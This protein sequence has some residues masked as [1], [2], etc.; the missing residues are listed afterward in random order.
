MHFQGLKLTANHNAFRPG[1]DEDDHLYQWHNKELVP[2]IKITV[3]Y[4]LIFQP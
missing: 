1:A 3:K 2:I 4:P